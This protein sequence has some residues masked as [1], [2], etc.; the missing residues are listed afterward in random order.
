[1]GSVELCVCV[2]VCDAFL[3][4]SLEALWRDESKPVSDR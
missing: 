3:L 4:W 1:M 2:C